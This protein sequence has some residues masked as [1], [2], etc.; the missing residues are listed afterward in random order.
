M[1][2]INKF[3]G[4]ILGFFDQITGHYLLALLIFALLVKIIMLPFGIKQQKTS[5]KQAHVRP[6]E[7]AIR[8]KYKGR[9]DQPTQQKMQQEIMDLYQK[10]GYSPMSGCLPLLIQMPI[11]LIL[12]NV[13]I[14][15]LKYI[16]GYT[17]EMLNVIA[18]HLANAGTAISGLKDGVFTGRD[19]D[20]VKHLTESN[21]DGINEALTAAGHAAI[22]LAE[23]PNLSLFGDPTAL[24]IQPSFLSILVLIPILNFGITLLS[25]FI[26]KKL[27]FQPMQEQQGNMLVMNIVMAGMTAFIAFQ[28]PAA[29]GIYWLFN[30]ILG[31]IQQLILAKTMPL[32]RFTEEE[33]KAAIREYAGKGASKKETV[34]KTRAALARPLDE[35]E[36][37]DL[38]DY[39]SV[40]DEKPVIEEPAP[41]NDSVVGKAPLKKKK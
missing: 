3:F 17:E 20:L 15:P 33:Y 6:R 27:T 2:F 25:M 7:M 31:I 12:Y 21:V 11:L 39:H 10:E 29:I 22:D 19:I 28:V 1:S 14:S 37:A 32:P 30:S 16:C 8:A 5:I 23:L 36:Y 18:T 26:N 34:Q 24:A 9:T 40:Y 13:V 4:T 41:T 35:D 38:G